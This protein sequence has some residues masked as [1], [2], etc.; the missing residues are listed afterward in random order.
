MRD[1]EQGFLVNEE[2]SFGVY[3]SVGAAAEMCTVLVAALQSSNIDPDR[4]QQLIDFA[5]ARR[6][7]LEEPGQ[8]RAAGLYEVVIETAGLII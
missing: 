5:E 3:D 7:C 6:R 1:I 4:R 2:E 8:H